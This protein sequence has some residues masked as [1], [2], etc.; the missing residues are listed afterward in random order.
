MFLM[1]CL[2]VVFLVAL[3]QRNVCSSVV[4]AVLIVTE[5]KADPK[6]KILELNIV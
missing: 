6:V 3:G 4:C 1:K 2:G 5:V